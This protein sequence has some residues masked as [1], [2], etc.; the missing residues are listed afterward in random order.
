S[1]V[2][3]AIAGPLLMMKSMLDEVSA[4][5]NTHKK[6]GTINGLKQGNA[7]I[8]AIIYRFNTDGIPIS[9]NY[10]LRSEAPG[11]IEAYIQFTGDTRVLILMAEFLNAHE[12]GYEIG[13]REVNNALNE[14]LK[15]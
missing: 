11:H 7:M 8:R 14:D 13:I 1:S 2:V 6:L 12:E 3:L 15:N 9:D 4:G 10:D 5:K